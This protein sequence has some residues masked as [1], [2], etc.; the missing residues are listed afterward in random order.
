VEEAFSENQA[1][2]ST[3]LP[4]CDSQSYDARKVRFSPMLGEEPEMELT[5][6][7]VPLCTESRLR[8]SVR[9]DD[10]MAEVR[11]EKSVRG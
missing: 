9:L 1:V 2:G 3:H 8:F 6:V 4:V 7:M 10:R 11:F 5:C